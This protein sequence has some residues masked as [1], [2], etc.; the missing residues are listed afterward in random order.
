[1]MDV[2]VYQKKD[3]SPWA[4]VEYFEYDKNSV[5]IQSFLNKYYS[6]FIYNFRIAEDATFDL[7]FENPTASFQFMLKG[8]ISYAMDSHRH[9]DVKSKHCRLFY[10]PSGAYKVCFKQGEYEVIQYNI[11]SE[12]LQTLSD[13]YMLLKPFLFYTK[14]A[15][16]HHGR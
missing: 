13:R 14:H 3:I 2:P 5:L 15:S 1:M 6:I 10:F 8:N 7:I 4:G 12:C 16:K 9:L 11:S